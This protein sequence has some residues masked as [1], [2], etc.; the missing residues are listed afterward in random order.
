MALNL[1]LLDRSNPK[2]PELDLLSFLLID[3]KKQIDTASAK[4]P[5]TET[6]GKVRFLLYL[7]PRSPLISVYLVSLVFS[8]LELVDF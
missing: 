8:L 6:K 2:R 7:E 5:L 4:D 3:I 1:A